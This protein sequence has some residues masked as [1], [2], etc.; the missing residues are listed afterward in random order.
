M[1]VKDEDE[2]TEQ[3][4]IRSSGC[5]SPRQPLGYRIPKIT[6]TLTLMIARVGGLR[7]E[8]VVVNNTMNFPEYE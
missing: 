1:A 3:A 4:Q 6:L 2:D 5:A 8:R 7:R